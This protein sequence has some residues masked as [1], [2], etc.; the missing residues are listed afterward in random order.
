MSRLKEWINELNDQVASWL[1]WKM[2]LKPAPARI[3]K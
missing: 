3:K 1:N 2:G